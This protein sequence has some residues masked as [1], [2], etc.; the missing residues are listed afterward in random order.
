M[1]SLD[2]AAR[3]YGAFTLAVETS[4]D[5]L[6]SRPESFACLAL[7]NPSHF[8]LLYDVDDRLVYIVDPPRSYT[9]E[10]DTF[11]HAWTRKA[12]LIGRNPFTP[13]ESI[14]PRTTAFTVLLRCLSALVVSSFAIGIGYRLLRQ[15]RLRVS[16]APLILACLGCAFAMSGCGA[17]TDVKAPFPIEESTIL[18]DSGPLLLAEPESH[19]LGEVYSLR[20]GESM[21]VNT[22][23][24][25]AGR[26]VL[27]I[28]EVRAGCS[29]MSPS[30]GGALYSSPG[31]RLQFGTAQ[32]WESSGH[33]L[34]GCGSI[35][36]VKDGGRKAIPA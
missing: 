19:E 17:Q 27:Q 4:L 32:P 23:L 13:E 34:S 11:N 18:S 10:R 22:R 12:L 16:G 35:C 30:L 3:R 8:V 2:E 25:N 7:M 36:C 29:C 14:R 6:N 9:M 28:D 33:Q 26:E 21:V 15:R 5:N 24:S 31:C 1:A 20:L